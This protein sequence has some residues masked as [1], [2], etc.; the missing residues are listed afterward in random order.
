M[1]KSPPPLKSLSELTSADQVVDCFA[2]LALKSRGVTQSQKPYYQCRFRDA[3]RTVTSMIWAD[4]SHFEDCEKQWQQGQFFKLRG[5]YHEHEKYGPQFEIQQIRPV[6]DSDHDQG[7][8]PD[9][10]VESSRYSSEAMLEELITLANTEIQNE[11]LRDLVRSILERN[12]E[13]LK[14]LP[15]TS[16]K[17]YPFRGGWLEHVLS[18][19]KNCL[20]IVEHY[21]AHYTELRP[22]LN[23]DLLLA[24][25]MLHDIGRVKELSTDLEGS[26]ETVEGR[27]LGHLFLGRDLVRDAAKEQGN[28]DPE[29]LQLLEH[30][31]ISH[32]NHPEWG[33]PRLPLL[34][35]CIVLHHLD[36]L[37]AKLEMYVRC[38]SRDQSPGPFTDRDPVLKRGLLKDRKQ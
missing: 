23:K 21:S 37:D 3:Q 12:S 7:F 34:P 6:Q 36:D 1:A 4:T 30:L 11:P 16:N 20:R 2:M 24:G 26:E 15:A 17:F 35:E 31:I 13:A 22:P 18:V 28:L 38:L 32:L 33:S 9:L 5:T 29:L 14:R 19:T 25:A 8:N 10:L 27:L